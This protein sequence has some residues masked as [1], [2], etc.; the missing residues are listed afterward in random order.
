MIILSHPLSQQAIAWTSATKEPPTLSKE[1]WCESK[2]ILRAR[3]DSLTIRLLRQNITEDRVRLFDAV[4]SEIGS[5]SFDHN[6]GQW[7]DIS[8]ALRIGI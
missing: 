6:I 1:Q 3:I 2:D 7:R 8:V 4:L 5:N